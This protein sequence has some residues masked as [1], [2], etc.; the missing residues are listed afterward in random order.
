MES[1]RLVTCKAGSQTDWLWQ[2]HN[3]NKERSGDGGSTTVWGQ[4][5]TAGLNRRLGWV[6]WD[7]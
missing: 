6:N 7:G 2:G 1:G 3:R 5:G 4:K